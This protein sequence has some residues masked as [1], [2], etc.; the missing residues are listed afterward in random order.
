MTSQNKAA[1]STAVNPILLRSE[2]LKLLRELELTDNT[3]ESVYD[4]L[5]ELASRIVN[6]PVS[7][8]SM[9]A[10]DR[11]VFKSMYGLT[12]WAAEDGETPLSHSFCQYVVSTNKPM[13]VTDAREDDTLKDNLA[14]RDLN[15]I[16]YL[17]IPITLM[18]GQRLG[19]FCVIDDQPRNWSYV[20]IALM[21]ELAEILIR[22]IDL[23]ARTRIAPQEFADRLAEAQGK[24]DIL[25]ERVD[26][27]QSQDDI[28]AQL[29]ALR[30]QINI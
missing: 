16:G 19:S 6:A 18:D 4:R 20:E 22:E 5:T 28:L 27:Q 25:I 13:V 26:L 3:R 23:R 30:E 1:T 11:Q 17:G 2:R 15:V 29:R 24:I 12:G 7:L 10:S 14:I 21:Q 8:M 9:V